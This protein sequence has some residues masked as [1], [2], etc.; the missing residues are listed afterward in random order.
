VQVWREHGVALVVAMMATLLMSALGLAL[1][2]TT[3]SESMIARNFRVAGEGRYAA[4]AGIERALV[5]LAAA[6]DWNAALAGG[7]RSTFVDGAPFG[8]RTLADGTA[9]DLAE[10]GNLAGCQRT[11][12]CSDA[13]L[14]AVTADR[15]WGVNNPRWQLYAYGWLDGVLPSGTLGSRYYVV[16]YVGDDPS[17]DDGNPLVDGGGSANPGAG[18]LLLRGEALGPLGAHKIVEVTAARPGAWAG[19]GAGLTGDAPYPHYQGDPPQGEGPS[20]GASPGVRL[21]S[22]REVR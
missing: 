19:P 15:P 14:D 11:S 21:L 3:T 2:L 17:E 4:E 12:P 22:W 1:V 8:T 10:L 20:P 5:D 7:L 9:I 6:P 13:D 16:V 18:V